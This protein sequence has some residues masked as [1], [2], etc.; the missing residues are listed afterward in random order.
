MSMFND[1]V[2]DAKGNEESC[3]KTCLMLCDPTVYDAY[4]AMVKTGNECLLGNYMSTHGSLC[5]ESLLRPNAVKGQVSLSV[6][7]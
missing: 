4:T 7:A 1:I 2:W 5:Y 3:G 6:G